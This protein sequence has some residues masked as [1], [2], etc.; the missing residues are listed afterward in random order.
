[1]GADLITIMLVAKTG[2]LLDWQAAY[3]EIDNA[4]AE[5][6][7]EYLQDLWGWDNDLSE[8]E[9]LEQLKD[10]IR[11]C[12]KY[13]ED[14]LAGDYRNI[15]YYSNILGGYDLIVCGDM[16]WG[17]TPNGYDEF[18]TVIE[19]RKGARAAGFI[20]IYTGELVDA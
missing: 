20:D 2:K 15:N 10:M 4:T 3:K 7:P 6:I 1:M 9:D 19:F 8:P 14:A 12:F 11:G 16:S 17:D 5:D 18:A 13:V